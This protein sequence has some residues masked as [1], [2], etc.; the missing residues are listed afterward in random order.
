MSAHPWLELKI[1]D[2]QAA[3][4]ERDPQ[5]H[6]VRDDAVDYFRRAYLGMRLGIGVVALALPWS[7]VVVDWLFIDVPGT[8]RGS[9]SAYY[10][11]S[12]RDIFVGGLIVV[13][14]FLISYMNAKRKTYDYVLSTMAGILVILVAFFP[15]GRDL[16]MD[17]FAVSHDSCKKFL[18]P[19]ACNPLQ[20]KLGE[21]VV[22]LVHG[23]CATGFVILLA[24]LCIVFALREFG[25]GDSA[26]QLCGNNRNVGAVR[27]R[28]A[29]EG[30]PVWRYLVSGL[31]DVG[32][33]RRVLLYLTMAVA[34]LLGGIWAR[35]GA[36]ISVGVT[37]GNTY[38]GEI[39]AF[40]AFG[41]AWIASAKD[42]LPFFRSGSGDEAAAGAAPLENS[43]G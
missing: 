16:P 39:V 31:R 22:R 21:D 14:G 38:V 15:T 37:L 10:H 35:W 34:I 29:A 2:R 5:K 7:L 28:L 33:P 20:G 12:A 4:A 17:G 3:L 11:S 23:W 1:L 9:M 32:P 18:G 6:E 41:V 43:A 27:A 36:D 26:D 13:G 30:V 25:Y 24:T 40:T 8:V 42:L 19:P